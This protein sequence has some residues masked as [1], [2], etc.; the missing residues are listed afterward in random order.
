[1]KRVRYDP[2]LPTLPAGERHVPNKL[3]KVEALALRELAAIEA[4]LQSGDWSTVRSSAI[5][6][7]VLADGRATK[8]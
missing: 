5:K 1:V 3:T 4:A 7:V 8:K 6:L 2:T